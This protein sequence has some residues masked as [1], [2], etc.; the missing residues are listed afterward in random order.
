M[1]GE[2]IL[3][4]SKTA[5]SN[6]T[7]DSLINFA[8]GQTRASLNDSDRS[9][10]AALA[11]QRDYLNGSI[12]TTGSGNAQAFTSGVTFTAYPS[13]PF[14]VRLKMGFT[15]T[16]AMTLNMDG[17][18][19]KSVKTIE[20]LDPQAG[21]FTANR[22]ATFLW[23]ATN[24]VSLDAGSYVNAAGDTMTGDLKI[25]K[26][27]AALKL[28]K[29][30][31]G[32]APAINAYTNDLTRWSMIFGNA[33][34]ESGSNV[35]SNFSLTRY[36]DAGAAID[37]P[38]FITRST[39]VVSLGSGANG[40]THDA[41]AQVNIQSAVR[42]INLRSTSGSAQSPLVFEG[43]VGSV[44]GSV[45][46]SGSN[47][48]YQ[49]SSDRRLK[50]GLALFEDGR[51]IVEQLRVYDYTWKETG[52]PDTGLIAQDVETIFPNA[53]GVGS[54]EPGDRNFLPYR[55]D[56]SKLVPVLVQALQEAFARID[57]LEARIDALRSDPHAH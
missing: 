18:G 29:P 31:S 45:D 38:L 12:T 32:S 33:T 42:G 20:G 10:M 16:A 52:E 4:W 5:A 30:A 56:N 39:G 46:V 13:T 40:A 55:L 19:V 28:N 22:Y 23:D 27:D 11:K 48:T 24:F 51:V 35:G 15:N 57:A 7:A 2:N 6:G 14:I 34:A 43:S 49:T 9:L 53:V 1:P 44:V 26:A 21:D 54:G 25:S 3:D 8:E 17:I 47:T 41:T 36:T 50:T 37:T